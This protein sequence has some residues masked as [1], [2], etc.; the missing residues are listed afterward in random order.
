M[1]IPDPGSGS[2]FFPSR[3][4]IKEFKYFNPN[5]LSFRKYDPGCSSR[6]RI[7]IFYPSRIPDPGSKR[8]RIPDPQHW[9]LVRMVK[10]VNSTW[11]L[12]LLHLLAHQTQNSG[13]LHKTVL[14][15]RLSVMPLVAP[16]DNDN[17]KAL[18]IIEFF[19]VRYST[20]F[21]LPSLRFHRVGGCWDGTQ[22]CC[23]FGICDSQKL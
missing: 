6:I 10:G 22:D 15:A 1:F 19:S 13:L 16:I 3:I 20:L 23:N 4:R 18:K 17:S 11:N 14:K 2:E 7:P 5:F 21:H 8:Y 12:C 9:S